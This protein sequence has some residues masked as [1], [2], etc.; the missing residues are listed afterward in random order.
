MTF[1]EGLKQSLNEAL[2]D[3]KGETKLRKTKVTIYPVKKFTPSEIRSIRIDNN[4]SQ[5]VF[6]G[7]M[8]VSK[9]TVEAWESGSSNPTGT[10][11]RLLDM[12]SID[13]KFTEKYPYI[14][15]M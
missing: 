4:M 12:L 15:I 7:Y 2:E 6:A 3:A 11:C 14:T 9:K 10:A 5:A 1:Y 8:G 13:N